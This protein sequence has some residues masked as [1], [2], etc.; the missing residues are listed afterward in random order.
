[1]FLYPT[2]Q[3]SKL[4]LQLKKSSM[5]YKGTLKNRDL[6]TVLIIPYILYL[7]A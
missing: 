2:K 5:D 1:M 7:G 6:V 3:L 4:S